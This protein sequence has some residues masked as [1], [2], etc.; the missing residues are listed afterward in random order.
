MAPRS[1]QYDAR[2]LVLQETLQD[3]STIRYSY[4]ALGNLRERTDQSGEKTK[5]DVD[6]LGRVTTVTY[7]DGTTEVTEY[8]AATGAVRATK[9]RAGQWRSFVFDGRGAIAEIH[10][11]EQPAAGNAATMIERRTYDA[12]GR[13]Q[14]VANRDG[15]IEYQD[16]DSL[17]RPR[18]T[19]SYRYRNGSGRVRR[20]YA[21]ARLERARRTDAL[22]H[23]GGRYGRLGLDDADAVADV[24]RRDARRRRQPDHDDDGGHADRHRPRSRS[25]T[26]RDAVA[27]AHGRRS[28]PV[29]LRLLGRGRRDDSARRNDDAAESRLGTGHRASA[30]DADDARQ[31]SRGDGRRDA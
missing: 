26:A 4:D 30:R 2:G 11:V 6:A 3:G 18:T 22:A 16:L 5:Y 31:H 15:A 21:V 10:N 23:A 19:R 1:M 29:A 7:P 24:H 13:L 25:G 14:L 8:E 27:R 20:A 9:N 28:A 12:G 17:G